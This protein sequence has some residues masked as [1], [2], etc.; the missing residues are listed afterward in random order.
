MIARILGWSAW[1]YLAA[2]L[3]ALLL[4]PA[5][6]NG[7]FGIEPDPLSATLALL[8]TLPWS[9]LISRVLSGDSTFSGVV[10]IVGGLALNFAILVF[11]ARR[12]RRIAGPFR[13]DTEGEP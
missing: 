8:L 4:I 13:T 12:L 9:P 11:L 5:S 3:L 2:G 1:A 6:A 7:W 10:A